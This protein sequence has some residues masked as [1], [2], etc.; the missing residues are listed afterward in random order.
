[1]E[2]KCEIY[3]KTITNKNYELFQIDINHCFNVNVFELFR[4]Y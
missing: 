1:M 2:K 4:K 3:M